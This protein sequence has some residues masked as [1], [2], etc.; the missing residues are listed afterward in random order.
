MSTDVVHRLAN[1]S[2]PLVWFSRSGRF[3]SRSD[4]GVGKR[5]VADRPARCSEGRRSGVGDRSADRGAKVLNSRVVL[6]DIAKDNPSRASKQRCAAQWR[7]WSKARAGTRPR[8][9]PRHRRAVGGC[10]L[11]RSERPGRTVRF[12]LRSRRPDGPD[13]RLLSFPRDGPV[14]C[15]GALEAVGLDLKSGSSCPASGQESWRSI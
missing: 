6:L 4:G 15:V 9:R 5:A 8:H 2:I 1:E 10:T 12:S 3:V 11:Q 7:R 14:R 13:E